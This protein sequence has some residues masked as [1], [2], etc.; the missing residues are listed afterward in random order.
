MKHYNIKDFLVM[1]SLN[2]QYICLP[3][4]IALIEIIKPPPDL[5]IFFLI[6]FFFSLSPQSCPTTKFHIQLCF[7]DLR[8]IFE[9]DGGARLRRQ[10]TLRSN[11][12]KSTFLGEKWQSSQLWQ[13]ITMTF[14][15]TI[16]L[17]FAYFKIWHVYFHV[18]FLNNRLNKKNYVDP[19]V[20]REQRDVDLLQSVPACRDALIG[21]T[22]LA[23]LFS[24]NYKQYKTM[25]Y[26]RLHSIPDRLHSFTVFRDFAIKIV[27][28]AIPF[29]KLKISALYPDSAIPSAIPLLAENN[30]PCLSYFRRLLLLSGP[31]LS[32]KEGKKEKTVHSK[33]NCP[34]W[35]IKGGGRRVRHWKWRRPTFVT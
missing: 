19:K 7:Y 23:T 26:T 35:R 17:R 8:N 2:D 27:I 31:I 9:N 16:F 24:T 34:L 12:S 6:F 10:L 32:V 3:K 29:S 5:S 20:G 21:Q 1:Y 25:P 28:S 22:K 13:N 18:H 4:L 15:D 30:R 11:R 33:N 14:N